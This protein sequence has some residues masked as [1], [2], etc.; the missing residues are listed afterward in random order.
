MLKKS[1]AI[2]VA[3]T[4]SFMPNH[5]L[6]IPVVN[7]GIPKK[8]TVPKSAN[9]SIAARVTP[10]VIAGLAIGIEILKIYQIAKDPKFGHSHKVLLIAQE[11]RL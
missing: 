6:N 3:V 1:V 9:A 4:A 7:V 10:K 11:M 2:C 5:V 8:V